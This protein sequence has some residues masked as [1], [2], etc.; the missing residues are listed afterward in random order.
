MFSRHNLFSKHTLLGSLLVIGLLS[1]AGFSSNA[2]AE[3]E[4]NSSAANPSDNY[5][6]ADQMSCLNPSC[7]EQNGLGYVCDCVAEAQTFGGDVQFD[8]AHCI[9]CPGN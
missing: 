4:V 3:S 2:F 9:S 1:L 6:P 8:P 5:F 7:D